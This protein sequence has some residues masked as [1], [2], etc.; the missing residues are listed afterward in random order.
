M[1]RLRDPETGVEF[2]GVALPYYRARDGSWQPAIDL[3]P[4]L[5]EPIGTAVLDRCCE[6]G[7]TRQRITGS[8]PTLISPAE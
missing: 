1:L 3:P 7:I 4:E 6:L 8:S 5:C 2:S